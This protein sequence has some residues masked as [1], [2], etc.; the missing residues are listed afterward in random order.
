MFG[1]GLCKRV[2]KEIFENEFQL[3]MLGNSR[4]DLQVKVSM[5]LHQQGEL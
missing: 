4:K 2:S 5:I 3:F 1:V